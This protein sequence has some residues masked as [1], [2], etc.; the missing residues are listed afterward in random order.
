M[1]LIGWVAD[2]PRHSVVCQT[3]FWRDM[4]GIYPS[5]LIS[6]GGTLYSAA[7]RKCSQLMVLDILASLKK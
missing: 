7:V 2:E 1:V 3:L 4:R 5:V 6:P